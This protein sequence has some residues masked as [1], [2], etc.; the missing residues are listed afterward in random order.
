MI[1]VVI[2]D[3]EMK[4]CQLICGII[5]WNSVDMEIVGVAH[6]GIEA[7]DLIKTLQPD[8]MITD[9]RMPG[10]DGLEMISKG[11]QIKKDIDFVI[12]SGYSHFEYAQSAIKY[13]VCDYLL[14]PIKKNELLSTLNKIREKYRQR[15]EQ[16]SSEEQLKIRLQ[17]DIDNLRSG[18]FTQVLLQKG[19][20]Q[21]NIEIEKSNKDYHFKFQQGYFQVFVVK[22]DCDYEDLYESSIKIFEDK[23]AQIL[24][25]LLKQECFDIEICFQGSRAYCVLNY[26]INNKKAIRKQLRTGLDEILIQKGVFGSIEMTIGLGTA[27]EDINKLRVSLK[28][29]ESAI[30]QRLI[31]GTGK[32]IEDMQMQEFIFDGNTLLADLTNS[33]DSAIEI[34]D[35]KGVI[36]AIDSL[37][38]QLLNKP[39]I[40]GQEILNLVMDACRI[41]IM[42]LR[43]HKLNMENSEHFFDKFS[44]HADL[45]SSASQLFTFLSKIIGESINAVIDDKKQAD[46]KP[47]RVAKQYIQKNYMNPVTLKEVSSVAGFNDT[48]FSYLFKKESGKNFLE[49]LSEVRMDKAK[50]LLRETNLSI[51]DIC[52]RV[53]YMDL[54][55]FTKSF[56]RYS[57][58]KPNE[59]R[60]LYS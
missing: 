49:Y 32:L 37:K 44:S 41:Y 38:E 60:K 15:S 12:I 22:V 56:K 34:L 39:N 16:L 18:F 57:G 42:L 19:V 48:Y 1:R 17:S 10:Y 3:D 33:M 40:S 45:C 25:G 4:V 14:K 28:M 35:P 20:N 2:A 52:Q 26:N 21:E 36:D 23:V 59:F 24:R 31:K 47:I 51:A 8:L 43:N 9:I 50:E 54:K 6:N 5:D 30:E 13:G 53:G 55:H 11:K 29:A 58:L 46:T 7:L 27:V